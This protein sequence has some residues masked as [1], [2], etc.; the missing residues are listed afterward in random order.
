M[1]LLSVSRWVRKGRPARPRVVQVRDFPRVEAS[2]QAGLV[3]VE[4]Q[5]RVPRLHTYVVL[6]RRTC[7][8]G[9]LVWFFKGFC[10]VDSSGVCSF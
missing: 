4:T 3:R 7:A 8:G 2:H 1:P 6:A 9:A 10:G 5:S